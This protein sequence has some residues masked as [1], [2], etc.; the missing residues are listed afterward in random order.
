MMRDE[1]E[2]VA[3]AEDGEAGG[4]DGGVGLRGVGVVDAGGAAG[5]DDAARVQ[6]EDLG[7]R[8]GAGE[9]DGEDVELADAARDELRVLRAEVEDDDG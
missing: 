4:E 6:R 7:E 8:R 2:A 5:E 3:D 1:L 9:D